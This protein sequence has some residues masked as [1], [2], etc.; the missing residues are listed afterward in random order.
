MPPAQ[1]PLG[2]LD[3]PNLP[4]VAA[5]GGT[6]SG[7]SLSGGGVRAA[8][9]GLGALQALDRAGIYPQARYLSAVSGGSYMAGAWTIARSY[10]DPGGPW[11]GRPWPWAEESAEVSH[12]RSR[13]DYL[14]SRDGGLFGAIAT[15]G[16]GLAINA[17][18]LFVL[19]WLIARPLGWLVGSPLVGATPDGF[20]FARYVWL[21]PLVWAL[22]AVAFLLVWVLLQRVRTLPFWAGR[23]EVRAAAALLVVVAAVVAALLAVV[24]LAVP[25]AIAA[26]G[27][28][29]DVIHALQTVLGI[30][31]VAAI[32]GVLKRPAMK[33]LP[34]A[35]GLLVLLFGVAVGGQIAASATTSSFSRERGTYLAVAAA[36]AVFYYFADPDWW[37]IQPY[38]RGRLRYAYATRRTVEDGQ[39]AVADFEHQQEKHLHEYA[40]MRPELVVCAALNVSGGGVPTR[41]G[42]PGLQLHVHAQH[43]RVQRADPGRRRRHDVR[44]ADRLVRAGLPPLGHAPAGGHDGGRDVGRGGELGHGPVQEGLDRGAAGAGQRPPRHVDA[45]PPLPR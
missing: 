41:V 16:L 6:H 19:L 29:S 7:I 31:V 8:T 43:R 34:R 27:N 17:G 3:L 32:V 40:G 11:A 26:V 23:S 24:L 35:G 1:D 28:P 37:S 4:T 44:V 10:P 5:P 20:T 18:S 38:Y 9:Y 15:L 25:G 33:L 39:S 45:Q 30:G 2:S 36:F 14:R 22:A 21:P 13:L 42:V 12:F